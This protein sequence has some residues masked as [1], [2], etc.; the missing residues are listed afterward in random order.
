MVSLSESAAERPAT[1]K[2]LARQAAFVTAAIR[3]LNRRGVSGM[4]LADV[5]GEMGVAPKA[6]AYYFKKK[7][8]LA[9]ACFL[10]GL[11]R[12]DGFVAHAALGTTPEERVTTLLDVY[13][14]FKRRASLGEVEELT[15]PN[16]IRALGAPQVDDAYLKIFRG[17]R[18][19]FRAPAGT[20]PPGPGANA[21]TSL[22]MGELH[23]TAVWLPDIFAED[24]PRWSR[25]ASD[26]ILNGLAAPGRPWEPRP[27]SAI[28]V[29][30]IRPPDEAATPFILAATQ[31]I[32]E[33]GYHGASVDRIS[34]RLNLSKG[35]FY[36]HIDNKDDLVAACFERTFEVYRR[37]IT[38]A[39]ANSRSGLQ[40][41]QILAV[42][43]VERQISGQAEVLRSSAITTLPESYH[44]DL[45]ARFDRIAIRLG[46]IVSDGMADGSIRPV[47]AHLA[48][49]MLMAM[50]NVADEAPF[51]VNGLT[52]ELAN[53]QFVR[54]FFEGLFVAT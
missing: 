35:A 32:N 37:A 39:E 6:I 25:R 40:T 11:E 36:H 31:V 49:H 15:S 3:V 26:L 48:A 16:D 29:A 43:L 24:Y 28:D 38:F 19:L 45:V 27:L 1:R 9:A 12:L 30:A 22:L 50:I 34:A 23:W 42:A 46:A 14:D 47:N 51:F 20:V 13:F 18:A 5:A 17:I 53:S 41:L 7:E 2:Y 54:P 8:D 33:M 44:Q 52:P 10:R 21:R 4:T